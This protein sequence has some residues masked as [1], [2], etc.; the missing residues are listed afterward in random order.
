M[1]SSKAHGITFHKTVV[2]ATKKYL[3]P[4]LNACVDND[5]MRKF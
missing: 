1:L 5:E 4:K 2:S 3:C